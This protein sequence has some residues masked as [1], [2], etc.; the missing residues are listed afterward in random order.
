MPYCSHHGLLI[1][2]PKVAYITGNEHFEKTNL[3]LANAFIPVF[4]N[5]LLVLKHYRL[6]NII[7]YRCILKSPFYLNVN[8]EK[9]NIVYSIRTVAKQRKGD[10]RCCSVLKKGVDMLINY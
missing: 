1:N 9:E 4:E 7:N 5:G 10:F 2:H 3:V 8:K 6:E